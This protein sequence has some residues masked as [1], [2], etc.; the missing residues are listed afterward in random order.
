MGDYYAGD[1]GVFSFLRKAAGAAAGFIPGVG[2]GIS[3]LIS[4]VGGRGTAGVAS[5]ATSAIVRR[6]PT[7]LAHAAAGIARTVSKHPVLSAAG[8]AG[9]I[10]AG[11]VAMRPSPTGAGMAATLPGAARMAMGFRR[12][13]RMRVTNP[14]ALRRAIRR[15][16]GFKRLALR[17]LKFTGPKR[18]RGHAYFKPRRK[19]RV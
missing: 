19:K 1:P 9:A 14:R 18:P 7:P 12:R 3:R 17:V 2:G 8:A 13:R 16:E 11:A 6:L 15:A 4:R 5:A 10:S